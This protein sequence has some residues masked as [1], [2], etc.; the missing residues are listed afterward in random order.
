LFEITL[1]QDDGDAWEKKPSPRLLREALNALDAEGGLYVGNSVD[2]MRAARAAGLM[3]VGVAFT[4]DAQTLLDAGAHW[5]VDSLEAL[6]DRLMPA[7][8][9]KVGAVNGELP[10]NPAASPA[11]PV[12]QAETSLR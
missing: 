6:E 8:V 2:D 9:I 12:P 4:H 1:C 10:V 3:A 7:N 5:V 11:I